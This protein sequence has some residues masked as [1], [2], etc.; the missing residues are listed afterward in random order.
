MDTIFDIVAKDKL[1]GKL[2]NHHRLLGILRDN[3]DTLLGQLH[4]NIYI[5]DVRDEVLI[6]ETSNPIWVSEIKRYEKMILGRVGGIL[7]SKFGKEHPKIS[8]IKVIISSKRYVAKGADIKTLSEE[9]KDASLEA[10]VVN[11][12]KKKMAQGFVLC[13]ACGDILTNETI[14]VFCRSLGR[15]YPSKKES[16]NE[17]F[18]NRF[19]QI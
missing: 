18:T 7:G 9:D 6:F 15:V 4:K 2:A 12:N 13:S 10:L 17:D 19:D 3:A 16:G 8:R 14:C 11:E 1:L 5:L